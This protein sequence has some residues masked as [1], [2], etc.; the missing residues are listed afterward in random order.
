MAACKQQMTM[1]GKISVAIKLRYIEMMEEE[2]IPPYRAFHGLERTY[3][4]V[5]DPSQV[6]RWYKNRI[7]LREI[8]R[9]KLRAQGGGRRAKLG[10][11]EELLMDDIMHLRLQNIQVKLSWVR[12]QAAIIARTN[13]VLDFKA[14]PGW[15]NRFMAR[16]H[17]SLRRVTNLTRLSDADVIEKATSYFLF[18]H[19]ALDSGK[20][21]TEDIVLMDE[22][23][24]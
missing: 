14:S 7:K 4:V 17:L 8:G 19:Q 12:S 18:L 5:R 1:K 9:T 22:T 13:G 20:Y 23:A 16:H 2:G 3:P 24:V 6:L 21:A 15:L 10:L 11:L